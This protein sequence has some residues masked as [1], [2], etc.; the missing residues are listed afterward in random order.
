MST[1]LR[2][3]G[4]A[5]GQVTAKQDTVVVALTHVVTGKNRKANRTFWSHVWAVV[6]TL[7][8]QPGLV[9]YSVRRELLGNEGWTMTIWQDHA[10]VAQF[11]ASAPHQ[12]AMREGL[13]ALT[14]VTFARLDVPA[15][16]IPMPW[17][18]AE[19][20]LAASDRSYPPN[21]GAQRPST[22]NGATDDH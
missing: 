4:F 7:P 21:P 16:D 6:E 2:G 20:L 22:Q 17:K 13:P 14:A 19:A 9:A 15:D 5:N 1:P 12:Q 10:S 18:R 3:P 8:E 11:V